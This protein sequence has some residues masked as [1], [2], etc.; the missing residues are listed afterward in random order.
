MAGA[1]C[2]APTTNIRIP[3]IV[4]ALL[5][6]RRGPY[7]I[8]QGGDMRRQLAAILM[9]AG[10]IATSGALAHHSFAMFDQENPVELEGVVQEFK[11]TSP[12]TF[13]ILVV[14]QTDG[15]TQAWSLEGGAPS[16]LVRDGWSSKSLK[17]G[18]E[19]KM[20]IEPLRS[21]A[22]G[23][24]WNVGKTK[25]RDGR[26][27]VVRPL[28][29]RPSRQAWRGHSSRREFNMLA[30]STIGSVTLAQSFGWR[31]RTPG[32]SMNRSTRIGRASGAGPAGFNGIRANALAARRSLP[33]TPEY[34]TVFEASLADQA[35]GGQGN[36]PTY[37]CIPGGMPRIMTV[38]FPME[39][40]ISPKT[41]YV[42]FDYSMPRRIYTDG[43]DW[44]GDA[45]LQADLPGLFDRALG[46]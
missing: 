4:A 3:T 46:G 29:L 9:S 17:T 37:K 44:P 11:F 28:S 33:L 23:G 38:V 25:F 34:Q 27:I 36:D 39:I 43:R 15:S 2:P 42:L 6:L 35:A 31:A 5:L 21:G 18:D 16:A 32:H 19:L 8:E 26:P 24:S 45:D 1:F 30:R 41:T 7:G 40:V 14:K 10:L 22:P 12:H 20:T 13:I